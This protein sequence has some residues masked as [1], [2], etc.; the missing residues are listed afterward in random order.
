MGDSHLRTITVAFHPPFLWV[1]EDT[2]CS[3]IPAPSRA[4]KQH[5]WPLSHCSGW[6]LLSSGSHQRGRLQAAFLHPTQLRL[7]GG[8][9]SPSKSLQVKGQEFPACFIIIVI[10]ILFY[11]K[12][13]RVCVVC[14]SCT[15][16]KKKKKEDVSKWGHAAGLGLI[17]SIIGWSNPKPFP[18]PSCCSPRAKPGPAGQSRDQQSQAQ[19]PAQGGVFGVFTRK[20]SC[21]LPGAK[22]EPGQ[23]LG[24]VVGCRQMVLGEG[25]PSHDT[26]N[27]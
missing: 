17:R 7:P 5:L 4:G 23:G 10:I 26:D 19:S 27:Y 13:F 14:C 9:I 1:V 25:K 3:S 8:P 22:L 20:H 16:T 18:A 12:F 21:C 2:G 15:E 11:K 24:E 6:G